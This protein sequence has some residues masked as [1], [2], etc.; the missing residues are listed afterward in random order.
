VDNHQE[1]SEIN[2]Y[3]WRD[4]MWISQEDHQPTHHQDNGS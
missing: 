2:I 4:I 3:I 1:E